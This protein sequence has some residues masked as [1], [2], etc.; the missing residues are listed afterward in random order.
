MLL[1]ATTNRHRRRTQ[2]IET[3]KLN[4]WCYAYNMPYNMQAGLLGDLH[5]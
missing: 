4:S 2:D 5:G 1:I 3:N